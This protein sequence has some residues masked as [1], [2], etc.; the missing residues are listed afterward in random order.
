MFRGQFLHETRGTVDLE[1]R[2]E[3]ERWVCVARIG[4]KRFEQATYGELWGLCVQQV[5]QQALDS[6]AIDPSPHSP[7]VK[8][9][10]PPLTQPRR[11]AFRSTAIAPET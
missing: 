8:R 1:C 9:T 5:C 4:S 10:A 11:R 7:L 6:P 3:G 2:Q